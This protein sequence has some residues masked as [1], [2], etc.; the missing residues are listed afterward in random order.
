VFAN[1]QNPFATTFPEMKSI[2]SIQNGGAMAE[3]FVGVKIGDV[4]N[5]AQA[6]SLM[7][8]DDRTVNTLLFDID[9]RT[10]NA[11]ET[12]EVAFRAAERCA[13]YQFTLN[14]A[15]LEVIE[16]V[17]GTDMSMENFAVFAAEKALTTSFNGAATGAFTVKFRASQAG[18]LSKMLAV[19]SRITRAVAYNPSMESEQVAFRF[20]QGAN[21]TISGLGFELYQN[22][23][24]PF[25]SNTQIGFYLPEAAKATLTVYDESGRQIVRREGD[26]AKGYNHFSLDRELVPTTGLLYY[27]VE[28]ATDSATKKM[29][30]T[31]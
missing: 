6:N 25:V 7:A 1:A 13:G 10:V 8:A 5:T 11:G 30:Q 23:P 19:S 21:T 24:N 12:V 26:F 18:Q 4:N 20:N 27:K 31:K 28:T 17:P 15:G 14:H 2:A 29:T 3:D 16:I 22:Q 9:D